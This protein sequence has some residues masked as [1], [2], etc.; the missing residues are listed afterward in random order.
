[1]LSTAKETRSNVSL[2]MR[3]LKTEVD[4]LSAHTEPKHWQPRVSLAV[5]PTK[6]I[7]RMEWLLEKATEIGIDNIVFLKCTRSER[8]DVKSERLL[9]ILVS[10]L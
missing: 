7:D 3:I 9:K 4:I 10:A 6:N 1:M 5:S 2:R 8:K